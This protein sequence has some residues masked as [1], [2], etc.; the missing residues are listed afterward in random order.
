MGKFVADATIK[1]M[2]LAGKI[3]R[4][5]KVVIFGLTFKE[6]CPDVRNS[7]VKDIVSCLREYGINPEVVDPWATEEDI[8]QEY[9]LKVKKIN[10]INEVDCIVIAVA[11][12]EFK[13]I[14]L[15]VLEKMYVKGKN[16]DK[17]LIDVK[18]IYK[19]EA[20]KRKGFSY[21]RL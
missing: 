10:E 14:S 9:E 20:V 16:R 13:D 21:W 18:G 1:Q 3:I 12:N 2:I 19:I 6:N 5:S 17:V 11:H 7:K 8:A 4:E 15:D